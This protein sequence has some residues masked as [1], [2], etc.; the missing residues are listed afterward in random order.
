VLSNPGAYELTTNLGNRNAR[1]CIRITASDVTLDGNGY[2]V[3]G[4][5]DFGY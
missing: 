1:V 5:S 3:D 2:R 4:V